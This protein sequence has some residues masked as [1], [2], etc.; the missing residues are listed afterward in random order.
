M[1]TTSTRPQPANPVPEFRLDLGLREELSPRLRPLVSIN[2]CRAKGP[3]P[4]SLLRDLKRG[5][6][7]VGALGAVCLAQERA[8]FSGAFAMVL[9]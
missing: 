8:T 7:G 5:P 3:V 1:A 9:L 2:P 4:L 6:H